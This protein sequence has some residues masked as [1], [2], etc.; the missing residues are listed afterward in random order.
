MDI[1][2]PLACVLIAGAAVGLTLPMEERIGGEVQ[3][4]EMAA[5]AGEFTSEAQLNAANAGSGSAWTENT[6]LERQ[7]D[8]HFYADVRVDGRSYTM[9]VD[10]GASVVALTAEDATAMGLQ[11]FDDEVDVV[12]QGASGPVRGVFATIDRMA[13][14]DHEVSGVRAIIIPEGAGISLLGQSFL[15]TLGSVEIANDR[16]VL[17]N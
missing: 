2:L 4:G 16:M 9:M 11:W 6:V 3:R 5:D 8:G 12:A 1:K 10:T 17:G 15:S 13:V 7:P 14:G